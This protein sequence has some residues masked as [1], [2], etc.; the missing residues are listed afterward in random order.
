ML[1]VVYKWRQEI[2]DIFDTHC[3][4]FYY[5]GLI[6]V[7][8]KSLTP[9]DRDVIYGR[10]LTTLA[11]SIDSEDK[12]TFSADVNTSKKNKKKHNFDTLV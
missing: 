5:W 1:G 10:P 9:F 2:L 11:L 6:A 12:H 3:H 7:V 4:D 8:T